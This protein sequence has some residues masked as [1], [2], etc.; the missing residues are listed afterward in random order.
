M[1]PANLKGSLK[2]SRRIERGL[3]FLLLIALAVVFMLPFAITLSDSLKGLQ[4]VY[5]VPR[6]W[7]PHPVRWHNF[8][9]IFQVLPFFRFFVNTVCITGLA[10]FGQVCSACLVAYSF[11]R[12]RWPFRDFCFLLLLSTIML[13]AQ[14]TMIPVFLLFNR[15]GWVN[16]WLPLIVP[17]YFG[18]TVFNVFLM[19]QFF[20]TIPLALEDAAK[21]DGCSH[22]RI[23]STIMIP[24]AKPAIATICVLSFIFYWND[25]MGPLI[26]LSDYTKYPIALGVYMFKDAQGIFPHYVMAA[27]LV[28][29]LPVL[30]L[31]FS[32][33]RYFVEG[34]VLTG[35]KG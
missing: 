1:A 13:P 34:I 27:S 8:V 33:Q 7:I 24:L 14:V 23:F 21:I 9:D 25:F 11:A 31:F 10:L 5:A 2:W 3:G 4:Q 28:S 29:I 6:I 35:V 17:A 16:S 32:A 19:R 22:F 18:G 26:Y 15:L 12:M 30:V 20:K